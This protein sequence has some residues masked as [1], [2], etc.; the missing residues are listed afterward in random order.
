M[1]KSQL[2]ITALFAERQSAAEVAARYGVHRA[3]VYKLKAWYLEEGDAALQPRS[4]RP[5]SSRN[6]TPAA[7]VELGLRLRKQLS[8]AGLIGNHSA[9]IVFRAVILAISVI[10]ARLQAS[11]AP[12]NARSPMI[13]TSTTFPVRDAQAPTA[14]SDEPRPWGADHRYP[15]EGNLGIR[16]R[17]E[18][19]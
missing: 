9:L 10:A 7:T 5:K 11:T 6:P 4:R 1:S 13:T 3:W 14:S 2:V 15:K 8:E 16:Q 17:G 19:D 12:V 18:A